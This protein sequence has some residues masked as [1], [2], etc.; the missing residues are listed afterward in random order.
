MEP[1]S[2]YH[3]YSHA[4]GFELL[5]NEDEDYEIFLNKMVSNLVPISDIYAYCLMP[6][7]FHFLAEMKSEEDILRTTNFKD[8]N[9]KIS[10]SLA[11]ALSGFAQKMNHKYSRMGSLFKRNIG[12]REI[13][14]ENDLCSVCHYIHAN[15][16]HH[17][18]SRSIDEWKYSSYNHIL[19]NSLPWLNTSK[20]LDYYGGKNQFIHYHQ[21]DIELKKS[22]KNYF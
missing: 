21:R 9:K 16:V 8:P 4:N 12:Q 5:F 19:H 2:I 22:E 6:N 10:R 20:V 18:F 1:G 14:D 15:P 17:G 11:N 13:L 7:H 3:L